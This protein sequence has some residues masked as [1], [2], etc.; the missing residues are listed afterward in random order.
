MST[1]RKYLLIVVTLIAATAVWTGYS[2]ATRT[3]ESVEPMTHAEIAGPAAVKANADQ[4]P[5]TVVTPHF[6]CEI[7]PG[8]NVLWCATFQIAWN[9]LYDLLGGPIQGPG[10]PE[11][12]SIL[13]KQAVTRRDLDEISYIAVAGKT[14]NGPDDIRQKIAREL[15]RKFKGAASPELLSQLDSVSPGLWVTY[16]YLFKDLPFQ[17][18]FRRMGVGLTFAGRE[19]ENFGI[20]QFLER[21]RNEAKAASQVLVYDYSELSPFS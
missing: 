6:E 3:D 8:K 14:T 5:G 10:A 11:M 4:L 19:V 21:Q 18:A 2:I 7:T 17:W 16:A 13:N 12:V 15:D 20:W 9:E 1:Q